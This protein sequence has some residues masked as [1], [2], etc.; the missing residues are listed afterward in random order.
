MKG[1]YERLKYDLRR[2][3]QCPICRRR[4]RTSGAVTFRYCYCQLKQPDGKPVL[5]KL[6]ADGVRRV[7]PPPPHLRSAAAPLEEQDGPHAAPAKPDPS[8]G[9]APPGTKAAS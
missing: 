4:E 2:I 8:G 1:P 6:I 7:G 5:M 3:W 9:Q